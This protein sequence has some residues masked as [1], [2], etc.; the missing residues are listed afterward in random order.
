MSNR[1]HVLNEVAH[2]LFPT[3]SRL[4]LNSNRKLNSCQMF[5]MVSAVRAQRKNVIAKG[6]EIVRA[7]IG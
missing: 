7:F 4:A 2:Y 5:Q 3:L 6:T 1:E